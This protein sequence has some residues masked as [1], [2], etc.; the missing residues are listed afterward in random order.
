MN[1]I[2]LNSKV[3]RPLFFL[4]FIISFS[5]IAQENCSNGIDDD[6]DGLID[7]L[8]P[9]CLTDPDCPAFAVPG[10]C[11]PIGYYPDITGTAGGY[12]QS[13]STA[14]VNI[15]IA[16]NSNRASLIIQGVYQNATVNTA[17]GVDD[18][19]HA[20][21]RVIWGRVEL[22]LDNSISSGWVEYMI[23]NHESRRFSWVDQPMGAATTVTYTSVGHDMTELT[24]YEFSFD[25]DPTNLMVGCTRAELDIS[26]YAIFYGNFAT[27]SM[28]RIEGQDPSQYP[29]YF[30]AGS[31][32]INLT[33]TIDLLPAPDQPDYI[34][35]RA[36]GI[37][38][39]R[40]GNS[41]VLVQDTREEALSIKY[42][43]IDMN[44]MTA[45]GN[46]SINN[47]NIP[48]MC[49]AFTFSDY[50]VTSGLPIV[51]NSTIM[52]DAI[53]NETPPDQIAVPD[54]IIE[55][56]GDQLILTRSDVY[57]NDY[58]EIYYVEFL[59]YSNQP[60]SSSFFIT[61]NAYSGPLDI[62]Y[63]LGGSFDGT[64]VDGF[65]DFTIPEGAKRGYLEIRA[66]GL[67]S[68][69]SLPYYV[70]PAPSNTT[71]TNG[72]QMYAFTE[73]NFDLNETTGFFVTLT[74]SSQQQ[75][76]A[77]QA[78]PIDPLV[79][80]TTTGIYGQL[81]N[82]DERLNFEII[83]PNTFRVHL[84]NDKIAYERTL[85]MT[86]LGSKVNLVY[87]TFDQNTTIFTGCDSVYFD[88]EVC[89]SGGSDLTQ[90]VPISF[91][92]GD[93]TTDPTAI[94]LQTEMYSLNIDQGQCETFTFG[95]DI[96]SLGGATAGDITIVLNDD[97]S[98]GG[99]PGNTIISTFTPLQLADQG[100]PVL[101]CEYDQNIITA[102]W[103]LTPPPPPT[104]IF[105]QNTFT[106]CPGEDA[107]IIGTPSGT[108]GE[109]TYSWSPV[110]GTTDQITVAPIVETWY[111][112]TVE[113]VC[114]SVTDS[115]K[116]EIGTVDITSIDVVD[117]TNCPGLV[118]TP[119][120]ITINPGDPSWLYTVTGTSVIGP[121]SS[122]NFTGL[123]GGIWYLINVEDDNGCELDTA[124]FV[125]LGA[126][127]VTAD[128][129][130]D[131]LR[132]VT[133]FNMFD[134]GAYVN[135]IA[136]GLTAPMTLLGHILVDLMQHR[137]LELE[138]KV[139]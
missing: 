133:C 12:K 45:S 111:Y 33:S 85:Q 67:W 109:F 60:Y 69:S 80:I 100:N 24:D 126:N 44:T 51:A 88:M 62:S 102:P 128:F 64:S 95:I 84:E 136:G 17:T 4:L 87:S 3:L 97:G 27:Q 55:V 112:L 120:E 108:T 57:G 34:Q 103:T 130:T 50:D 76:Y 5:S 30:D 26:Y 47:G 86:F 91:Y 22:D 66:N 7:C 56:V 123:D 18:L 81:P 41:G 32:P 72:N 58:N 137:Q 63:D 93:P 115:V 46:M 110:P 1:N 71:A 96:A 122:N 49:T 70:G 23:N 61:E 117:A 37:N 101:E 90:A 53:G 15:P 31:A 59:K 52:G 39:N 29:V 129:I 138:E 89:N 74:T 78:V 28:T 116:V 11:L 10:S 104:I 8:D 119:G 132:D 98:F 92:N 42:I 75:L 73:V 118:G 9:D 54:M 77:W 14:V 79:D 83:P 113:D 2:S 21:E 125:G 19:N 114:G 20:Q 134:G 38:Q 131:S 68:P 139:I 25:A 94:Y 135:N 99:T 13:P 105:N 16:P 36:I 43:L 107:T 40:Y 48:D 124:I 106:I 6:G 121:Q 82:S 35:L 65:V 127:A